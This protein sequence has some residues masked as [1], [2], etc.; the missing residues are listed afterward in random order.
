MVTL[1]IAGGAGFIGSTLVRKL[2]RETGHTVVNVDRPTYAGNLE[3]LAV[4]EEPPHCCLERAGVV[5][6][7]RAQARCEHVRPGAS[8]TQRTGLAAA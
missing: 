7:A 2:V 6:V 4:G 8:R 1:F 3:S 5:H